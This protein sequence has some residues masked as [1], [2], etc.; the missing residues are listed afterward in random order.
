MIPLDLHRRLVCTSRRR[1]A[2][3]VRI[4][5]ALVG[6]WK[7]AEPL[8]LGLRAQGGQGRPASADMGA[9]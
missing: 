6:S 8:T 5:A 1:A 9:L 3:P 4:A 7:H 2:R